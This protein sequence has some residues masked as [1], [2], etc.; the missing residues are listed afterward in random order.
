MNTNLN[1]EVGGREEQGSEGKDGRRDGRSNDGS[2][3]CTR[4]RVRSKK[5]ST[6]TKYILLSH[7]IQI[8]TESTQRGNDI[9]IRDF[10]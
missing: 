9:T 8:P 4:R 5:G 3:W 2:D 6:E 7:K 1:T 10:N